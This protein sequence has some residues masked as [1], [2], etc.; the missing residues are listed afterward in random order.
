M[1]PPV[2]EVP[3][4]DPVVAAPLVAAPV[5]AVAGVVADVD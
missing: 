5:V 3:D 2:L 1:A 4:V